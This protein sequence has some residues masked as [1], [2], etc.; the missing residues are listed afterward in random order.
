MHAIRRGITLIEVLVVLG[1][2]GLLIGLI[3]PAVQQARAV[4]A[5]ASCQNNLKQIGIALHNYESTHGSL[6]PVSAGLTA[7]SSYQSQ[8]GWMALILP[9][10]DQE[11]L[12]RASQ[13]ALQ[14]DP[15]PLHNPPHTPLV[16]II[17]S[18]GCPA[19]SR[20]SAP[21][22]DGSGLTMSYTS[23]VGI[24]G[25][26]APDAKVGRL[27]MFGDNLKRG[28]RLTQVT[29]GLSQTIHVG[30]RPPPNS[31][32]AG[33]WYPGFYGYSGLRGPNLVLDLGGGLL[34]SDDPCVISRR[35]F[36]P[37]RIDN[38]C[39]RYHLWSLHTGGA[40]FLFA[41]GTVRY[42]PYSAEPSLIALGS[43]DGGEVIAE[44]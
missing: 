8:L 38:P 18:Y 21:L 37:G 3:L 42:L 23:Y 10:M 24:S 33:W 41:D 25:S 26:L 36:G 35:C 9:Q 15:N 1:L 39:D 14:A 32:Q 30:E 40:N 12:F 4:S 19:D 13:D 7:Q 27:G 34:F 17:K 43:R 20:L 11:P 29:D 5:R 44:R 31:L 2:L 28:T 16:A 6:P 22:T